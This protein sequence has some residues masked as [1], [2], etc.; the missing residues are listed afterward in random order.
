MSIDRLYDIN[1][2]FSPVPTTDNFKNLEGSALPYNGLYEYWA[3]WV[4][5]LTGVIKKT[6]PD[7]EPFSVWIKY[8]GLVDTPSGVVTTIR[9]DES[10]MLGE[11]IVS[12]QGCF[13]NIADFLYNT[14]D[15]VIVSLDGGGYEHI[16]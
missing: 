5:D 15:D 3:D 2:K 16:V 6:H 4:G 10:W 12:G 13:A 1:I 9:T 8:E 14:F 11:T 7:Y